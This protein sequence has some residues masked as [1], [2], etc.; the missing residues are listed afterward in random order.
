M[1]PS[2]GTE[3]EPS[4]A[5]FTDREK[6]STIYLAEAQLIFTSIL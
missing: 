6:K 1:H 2:L 5:P 3:E 4:V